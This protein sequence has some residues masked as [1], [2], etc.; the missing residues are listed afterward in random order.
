MAFVEAPWTSREK[1]WFSA[2]ALKED[3]RS[4]VAPWMVSFP[5]TILSAL[6]FRFV[7]SSQICW[8]SWV[9]ISD[10]SLGFESD[11]KQKIFYAHYL[12]IILFYVKHRIS[13]SSKM[14]TLDR[15]SPSGFVGLFCIAIFPMNC[16]ES[17]A[18]KCDLCNGDFVA[19]GRHRW[20]CTGP[21][22]RFTS[23]VPTAP[24]DDH[25]INTGQVQPG[26]G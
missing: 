23:P 8:N 15:I 19:L 24:N 10:Y 7:V 2:D 5:P 11:S 4:L 16:P 1:K 20:R 21:K 9:P 14:T 17:S 12:G 6:A 25:R 22:G 13:S 18:V 26:N 3:S